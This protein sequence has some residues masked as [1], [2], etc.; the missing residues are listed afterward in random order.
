M[1]HQDT[2]CKGTFYDCAGLVHT[3][4]DVGP[5]GP[6][7]R[8]NYTFLPPGHPSSDVLRIRADQ[9]IVVASVYANDGM[10][11]NLTF[12]RPGKSLNAVF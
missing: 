3:V 7:E 4:S 9:H 5:I 6:F 12:W 1:V 11:R 8:M 2:Y 10:T